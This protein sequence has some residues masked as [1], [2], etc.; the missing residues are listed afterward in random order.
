MG[1]WACPFS[2]S[3]LCVHKVSFAWDVTL[4][5]LLSITLFNKL[6]PISVRLVALRIGRGTLVCRNM[7]DVAGY[8]G[9]V[10][11]ESINVNYVLPDSTGGDFQ[12]SV[13]LGRFKKDSFALGQAMRNAPAPNP[14][15][16]WLTSTEPFHVVAKRAFF[17]GHSG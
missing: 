9:C 5:S 12:K 7:P 16:G 2:S 4:V 6:R 8:L 15:P 10:T 1:V 17:R 13:F 14:L 3:R 11:P